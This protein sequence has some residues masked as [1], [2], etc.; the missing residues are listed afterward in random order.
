MPAKS[1]KH[2]SDA[3][4]FLHTQPP[5]PDRSSETLNQIH[6]SRGSSRTRTLKRQRVTFYVSVAA[7]T[8]HPGAIIHTHH[9]PT[10]HPTPAA[11]PAANSRLI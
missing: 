9:H 6:N 4:T 5:V 1:P 8:V 3:A 11:P 2:D 7:V 10:Y